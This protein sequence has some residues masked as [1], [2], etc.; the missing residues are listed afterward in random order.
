MSL[1][2][3][4]VACD[5]THIKAVLTLL[6]V[7]SVILLADHLSPFL[8]MNALIHPKWSFILIRIFLLHSEI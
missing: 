7:I 1:D 6:L 2:H 3:A 8:R 5:L 4:L